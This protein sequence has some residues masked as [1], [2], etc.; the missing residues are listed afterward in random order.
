M[1]KEDMFVKLG[2]IVLFLPSLI[3]GIASKTLRFNLDDMCKQEIL[4]NGLYHITPNEE[5]SRKIVESQHFKPARGLFKNFNSYG[6]ACVCF[7]D[8]APTIDNYLKNLSEGET[9]NPYVNPNIVTTAVKV[10]HK[11]KE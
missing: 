7:F 3:A 8:G 10:S 9:T 4:K 1:K 11:T 5:I 2:N 6:K